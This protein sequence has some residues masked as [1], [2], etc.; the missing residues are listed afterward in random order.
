[1]QT[2]TSI[3]HVSTADLVDLLVSVPAE[4]RDWLQF[5]FTRR[6]QFLAVHWRRPM[7]TRKGIADTIEKKVSTVVRAG[8][9]YDNIAD[10]QA[11]RETGELP[12]E[13]AGLPWGQWVAFPYLISHKGTLYVRLYVS[14]NPEHQTRAEFYRNGVQVDKESLRADCLASE[15][16]DDGPADCFT[17]KLESVVAS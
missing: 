14:K 3:P 7:K 10:V 9:T 13:N 15:F 11:K 16:R 1:M 2:A 17:V 6:G 12:A 4:K 5:L 8:I